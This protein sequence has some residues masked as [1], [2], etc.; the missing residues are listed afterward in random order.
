M[1]EI[2]N[3]FGGAQWRPFAFGWLGQVMLSA[4][5][6]PSVYTPA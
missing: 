2:F 6:A 5:A 1:S 3:D 4:G